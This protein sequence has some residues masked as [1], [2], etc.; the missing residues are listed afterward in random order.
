M[1][2][3]FNY[4][5]VPYGFAHCFNSQCV[6]REECLHHLAAENSTSQYPTLSIINP[7]RI[8]ADT[9]GCPYF[10]E[11]RK[12]RVAWG[13]RH[14]LDNVPHKYAAPMRNL[15]INHFG[16]TTYYRFYRQ[17]QGL[18]PKAQ[19]YIRQVFK[20][21]GIAEEPEFERFSEEYSYNN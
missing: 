4:Q 7:N 11:A 19:A 20:Q 6:H 13:I 5:S 2:D 14:L 3:N 16:K 21:N 9:T 15:F 10:R 1:K 17:E 12:Q 8:P 18:F